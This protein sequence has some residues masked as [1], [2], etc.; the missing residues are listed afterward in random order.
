VTDPDLVGKRLA[1]IEASVADLRAIPLENFD[2]DRREQAF[3]LYTL[4]M[5][6]QAAIDIA[7]H[8][9]S[10]ERAGEPKSYGD[11]F[12][13]LAQRKLLAPELARQLKS[14]AGMR[15]VIAHVYLN[16]DLA[17]VRDALENR[18]DDLL[19]FVAA[20]RPLL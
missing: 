16:V 20:I 13:L 6:I 17:E 10:D 3:A 12:M 4:L 19:S 2:T 15:N 8:I 14:M 7:L 1:F 11:A 18:L 5:A 9:V